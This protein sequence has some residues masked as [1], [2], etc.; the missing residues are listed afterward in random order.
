MPEN[1]RDYW[2]DGHNKIIG[3]NV[4]CRVYLFNV[5]GILD[6]IGGEVCK[7]NLNGLNTLE[8]KSYIPLKIGDKVTV[9]GFQVAEKLSEADIKRYFRE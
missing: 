1:V 8:V 9:H 4:L 7:V 5:S 2:L 3:D 6:S